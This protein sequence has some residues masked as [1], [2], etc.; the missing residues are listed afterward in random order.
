MAVAQPTRILL[1]F[2]PTAYTTLLWIIVYVKT[3]RPLVTIGNSLCG[4]N[5]T[6]G[7]L[8]NLELLARLR[9]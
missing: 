2:T 1:S 8:L 6:Q 7:V 3:R 5:G 9:F 4:G